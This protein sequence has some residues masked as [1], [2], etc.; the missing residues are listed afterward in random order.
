MLDRPFRP[1]R[2]LLFGVI[3]GIVW[4]LLGVILV[5]ALG[6]GQW[7]ALVV[8]GLVTSAWAAVRLRVYRRDM[9]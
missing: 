9:H 7:W 8:S 6:Q 5:I 2:F 4:V 3:V 1:R